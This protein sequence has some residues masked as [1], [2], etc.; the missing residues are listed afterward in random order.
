MTYEEILA[1]ARKLTSPNCLACPI[2]DGRACGSRMPGPGAKGNGMGAVRNYQGWQNIAVNTDFIHESRPVDTGCQLFGRHFKLPLFAGPV[3]AVKMHYGTSYDDI[4][5]N[6]MLVS[7]CAANGLAAFT[8]DGFDPSVFTAACQAISRHDGTGIPTIKP[9]DMD[10]VQRKAALAR[11]SGCLAM[12]MDIDGSG[13][14]FLKGRQPAA[15]PKTAAELAQIAHWCQKPFIIKGIMTV[16]SA[17]KAAEAGAAGIVVS[18][19]GGRIQPDMMATADVLEEIAAALK[20]SGLTILVD[21]GIRSGTDIFKALAMGADGVMMVRPFVTAVY[22]G[23]QEGISILTA[24][25][26]EELQD[27]MLSCGAGCLADIRPEMI[28]HLN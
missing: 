5:Y 7:G 16:K 28:R 12:A 10:T 1:Q 6:E 23:Q 13:L 21:G 3:G 19:H 22:G 17:L 2:C 25:L 11:E 26:A 18:N 14:P 9:W 8:G 4:Q 24:K 27:T 20:G 15:G